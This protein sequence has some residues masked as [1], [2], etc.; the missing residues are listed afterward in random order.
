M[1]TFKIK[2]KES[3]ILA[4]ENSHEIVRN[5][6]LVGLECE[7]SANSPMSLPMPYCSKTRTLLN[8]LTPCNRG[9]YTCRECEFY[10]LA[11][12]LDN[13]SYTV[14]LQNQ[15]GP[16][17][18]HYHYGKTGTL[19]VGGDGSVPNGIEIKTIG[20]PLIPELMF[21]A[22][23]N[24][25]QHCNIINGQVNQYTG[26]HF[27]ILSPGMD[28]VVATQYNMPPFLLHNILSL[29]EMSMPLLAYASRGL[30]NGGTRYCAF[31]M[32][33]TIVTVMDNKLLLNDIHR[34]PQNGKYVAVTPYLS[35]T[36]R[37]GNLRRLHLEFRYPDNVL[38]PSYWLF[39]AV[40]CGSIVR[41]AMNIPPDKVI[42]LDDDTL[43]VAHEVTV[44]MM[45]MGAG[46]R[47]AIT[48]IK[49]KDLE[50]ISR[51]KDIM[52]AEFSDSIKDI[53]PYGNVIEMLMDIPISE[54][55]EVAIRR[56]ESDRKPS[57]II[58]AIT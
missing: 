42:S 41:T 44:K 32:P 2:P 27:H 38:D 8:K 6:L 47:K 45:N 50:T 23:A 7:I 56:Y 17:R 5:T 19:E 25:V 29:M 13:A 3:D 53:D 28:S 57:T 58:E 18:D 14:F 39:H 22:Y 26:L 55:W 46:D 37:E 31:C 30:S 34:Q 21:S 9:I 16:S 24:I 49:R 33:Y 35:T 11:Q 20:I 48:N 43:K 1:K 10:S 40:L 51:I 36:S 15:L 52:I 54:S 4:W 12:Q